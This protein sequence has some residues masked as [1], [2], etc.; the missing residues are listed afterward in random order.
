MPHIR[1]LCQAT[2][3]HPHADGIVNDGG[4]GMLRQFRFRDHF[5]TRP[6]DFGTQPE[7]EWD[8]SAGGQYNVEA[9]PELRAV[10]PRGIHDCEDMTLYNPATGSGGWELT[11]SLGLPNCSHL[12]K[13]IYPVGHPRAKHLFY[14]DS[15]GAY[16]ANAGYF[17]EVTSRFSFHA[18][19]NFSLQ[20]FRSAPNPTLPHAGYSYLEV[21]LL[22]DSQTGQWA[23]VLPVAG[24]EG[25]ARFPRLGWRLTPEDSWQ[26][27]TEFRTDAHEVGALRRKPFEQRIIWE[28]IDGHIVL[29]LDGRRQVYY[30]PPELRVPE[31][32]FIAAGPLRILV[33]G[34]A[35]ILNVTQIRYPLGDVVASYVERAHTYPVA[36]AIFNDTVRCRTLAWEPEGAT[37]EASAPRETEGDEDRYRPRITFTSPHNYR[38]AVAYLHQMDLPPVISAGVGEPYDT[39]GKDVLVHAHG[40]MTDRWRHAECRVTLDLDRGAVSGLPEWK[41]NNKVAVV[42]GW[43]DGASQDAAAQFTGYLIGSAHQREGRRPERVVIDLRARDGFVRLERKYWNNLGSF[44]E[45]TLE[46]AFHRILNQCGIP[47]AKISFEGDSGVVIPAGARRSEPRFDFPEDTRVPDG[48]NRLVQ[49]CGYVW[50]VDQNGTWFCRPPVE[51]SGT[52]DFTLDD[53]TLTADDVTFQ[54]SAERIDDPV[55]LGRRSFANSVFVRIDRGGEQEEAWRRDAAS[56][57]DADAEGFIGDDWWHVFVGYDEQSASAL[58]ERILA[59]RRQRQR[60]LHFRCSGKPG[61]LPDHFLKVQASGIGVPADSLFRVIEKEWWARSDGEFVTEFACA[62]AATA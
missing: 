26:V 15:R 58:A 33:Y 35:A 47:E 54:L 5:S 3:D 30:L 52:P 55:F 48:L 2:I 24:T 27:L 38:R 19:P 25:Q 31:D 42:A 57:Q 43:D 62:R 8:Y 10:G 51:Y 21:Q 45:W 60:V 6:G 12:W 32:A 36:N 29:N 9:I 11:N 49:A 46:E 13:E 28:T 18:D 37:A 1:A 34:H 23:L 50:G 59:E 7:P 61:L 4:F 44:V 14:Y 53:D 41:G 22:G 17:G 16:D 20:A 40:R 39:Q 56:H